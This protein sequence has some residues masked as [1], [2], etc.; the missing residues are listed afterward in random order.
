MKKI[1]SFATLVVTLLA[2]TACSGGGKGIALLGNVPADA[3]L[4][5]VINGEQIIK[6][7][8]VEI[9][10]SDVTLP[11]AVT[12]LVPGGN[13]QKKLRDFF[14]KSGVETDC[15]VVFRYKGN[16]YFTGYV[17][18][19]KAFKSYWEKE[20]GG[21]FTSSNGME[22]GK[23]VALK[24][25]QFWMGEYD[26]I[27]IASEF[28]TLKEKD[29]MAGLAYASTLGAMKYPVA[30][31]ANLSLL[32]DHPQGAIVQ[33]GLAAA[34]ADAR[35]ISFNLESS[36]GELSAKVGILNSDCK[37]A[38]A[39]IKISKIDMGVVK[40]LKGN[41]SLVMAMDINKDLL[42]QIDNLP[43]SQLDAGVK[44]IISVLKNLNGTVAVALTFPEQNDKLDLY[45][46]IE[47]VD[48]NA[49]Q[50]VSG[51]INTFGVASGIQTSVEG[52]R[53]I[54]SNI[55]STA[56]GI[57]ID[58][59]DG[60]KGESFG[61]VLGSKAFSYIARQPKYSGDMPF[62]NM[63]YGCGPVDG[64]LEVKLEA[65]TRDKSQYGIDALMEFCANVR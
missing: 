1:L 20:I 25:N 55:P 21:T 15:F 38:K 48:K 34:F 7:C 24:E 45:G 46:V 19:E 13:D 65:R 49:A 10:G 31:I 47:C 57:S 36:K 37:P 44:M 56:P 32:Q 33:L 51:I 4:V 53:V 61:V 63:V 6:Q 43:G 11:A 52:K 23:G 40:S 39:N 27:K 22:W 59:L 8:G 42:E 58:G 12:K 35:Y 18:D 29:S 64:S 28:A 62:D 14:L 17:G 2:L 30:G 16:I 54:C 9:S 26:D 3:T 50:Q 41:P 5:A 60:L